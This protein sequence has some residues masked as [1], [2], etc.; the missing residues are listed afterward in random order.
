[1]ELKLLKERK[2][3]FD[4]NIFIYALEDS[5]EFRN[6]ILSL[7]SH[8]KKTKS[9]IFTSE[10]TLA[11]CLVKPYANNDVFSIRNYEN[12][13]KDSQ[14]LKLSTIT[15]EILKKASENKAIFHNKL[16]DAIH[17]ATAVFYECDYFITN[18]LG[19]NEPNNLKKIILKDLI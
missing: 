1:M 19:I 9:K 5:K 2:Y 4:T 13:I 14:D 11:E 10:L 3:Y 17:I 7:F 16:P 15:K 6:Q 12:N 18:D 8:I